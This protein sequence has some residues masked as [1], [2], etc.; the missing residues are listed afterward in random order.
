MD[1]YVFLRPLIFR[2]DPETAHRWT[3]AALDLTAKLGPFNPFKKHLPKLETE[4]MGLRFPNPVG[5]AAGLD[6]N[7]DHIE[8][9]AGLGFGFIEVGTVT[10]RP[11]P[12]NSKPRLFRLPEAEAL[13]NRMGFNNKGLA[14]LAGNLERLGKRGYILGVNLGKNKDTP[15]E[16][17]V[18]DYLVGLEKVYPLADYVTLN[19]SSPNTPGLRDLQHGKAL[20]S[21]LSRLDETRESLAQTHGRRLPIAVKIAPDLSPAQLEEQAQTFLRHHMDAIIATNTTLDHS[22]VQHLPH[23]S[24]TGGLSGRPVFEQSTAVVRRLHNRLGNRLPIIACGGILTPEDAVAKFEAGARLVQLYTG[25]IY[26]GP[27][28]IGHT[29]D[30][31]KKRQIHPTGAP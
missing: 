28:L 15:Q 19:I 6:K 5:L 26:H 2:L 14:H 9:L 21:L 13:I 16:K 20:D 7:G 25:L 24:E 11:Q 1:S 31:L 29:L 4:V 10:P 17:A 3:L 18:E 27:N 12:G 30:R 23:G 8:G 22:A